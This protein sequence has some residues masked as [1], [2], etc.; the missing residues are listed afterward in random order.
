[1]R[2]F[3]HGEITNTSLG[4]QSG[5]LTFYIT[6][7]CDD[8]MTRSMGGY[9]LSRKDFSIGKKIYNP[10]G[11][12]AIGEILDVLRM[13]RWESL[14]GVKVDVALDDHGIMIDCIKLPDSDEVFS[15]SEFFASYGNEDSSDKTKDPVSIS[16]F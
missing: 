11:L 13:V 3:M 14:I 2:D 6:V 10:A 15:M 7:L 1:M 8:G 5:I 9:S 12:V 4:F 16:A